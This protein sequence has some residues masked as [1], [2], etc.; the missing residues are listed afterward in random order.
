MSV[1]C[2]N[3]DLRLDL[4]MCTSKTKSNESFEVISGT[5]GGINSCTL[6]LLMQHSCVLAHITYASVL[7]QTK[8][9]LEVSGSFLSLIC[10]ITVVQFVLLEQRK[11]GCHINFFKQ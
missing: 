11:E 10:N 2:G 8:L 7:E 1:H 6:R 4:L 9:A 5:I 3:I